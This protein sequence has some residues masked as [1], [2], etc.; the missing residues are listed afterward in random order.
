MCV[1]VKSCQIPEVKM[2]ITASV[3]C[4]RSR[5]TRVYPRKRQQR[6]LQPVHFRYL[7]SLLIRP[8]LSQFTPYYINFKCLN[9]ENLSIFFYHDYFCLLLWGKVKREKKWPIF[10]SFQNKKLF[11]TTYNLTL[12]SSNLNWDYN[13]FL[14]NISNSIYM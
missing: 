4:C 13:S 3:P 12:V 5:S 14:K 8:Q 1:W 7:E 6:R 9:E 2:G 10:D 11:L